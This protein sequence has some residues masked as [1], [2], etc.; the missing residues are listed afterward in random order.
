[1]RLRRNRVYQ[2]KDVSISIRIRLFVLRH[3]IAYCFVQTLVSAPLPP[4]LQSPSSQTGLSVSVYSVSRPGKKR[5]YS[6]NEQIYLCRYNQA[7][8][9][10]LLSNTIPIIPSSAV[11]FP[12]QR[13]EIANTK[14]GQHTNR[15]CF[16]TSFVIQVF[17]QNQFVRTPLP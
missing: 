3:N 16:K 8:S 4:D 6:L 10:S 9:P 15:Y 1:M 14:S 17:P 5:T 13:P 12:F 7:T 2:V 11:E